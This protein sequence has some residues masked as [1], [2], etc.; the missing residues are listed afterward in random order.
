M[1][2]PTLDLQQ[3]A[4]DRPTPS[5][6]ARHHRRPW[7]SRYV[8]PGLI[9]VG[10]VVMLSLAAGRQLL[11]ATRVTVAPVVVK[12]TQIQAAGTVLFQAAGWI[13]PRP[14]SV[15]VPALTSGVLDKLL[16]VEGQDVRQGDPVATLISTD[17]RLLLEQAQATLA[18]RK[19]RTP[20]GDRRSVG[21]TG[22]T[23]E[24]SPSQG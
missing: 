7:I 12:Q 9:L 22:S 10:F 2:S 21:S 16:V 8:F 13:E 18:L 11:P 5:T 14:S 24:S 6:A 3:L 17:A 15:R 1:T 23:G 4:L 20:A 19:A